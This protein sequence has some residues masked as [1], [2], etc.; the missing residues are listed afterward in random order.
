MSV[1]KTGK[2]L[3]INDH[4][5]GW[6]AHNRALAIKRHVQEYEVE[7]VAGMDA[8]HGA[9]ARATNLLRDEDWDIIH[10]NFS[11][12]A[13][14]FYN[15]WMKNYNTQ[16]LVIT[17]IGFRMKC[18]DCQEEGPS[19][20][21][22]REMI[23]VSRASVGL[24]PKIQRFYN[25]T[26]HI[27]NGVWLDR[28]KEP[29]PFVIGHIGPISTGQ[30]GHKGGW[31][32]AEVAKRLGAELKTLEYKTKQIPHEEMPAWW[33]SVDCLVMP[34]ISESCNNQV[35]ECLAMNVPVYVT[36][37]G[38]HEWLHPYVHL[39]ERDVDSIVDALKSRF[40][41]SIIEKDYE[42]GTICRKWKKLYD[43]V[44]NEPRVRESGRSSSGI[45]PVL[46]PG[47]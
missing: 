21:Q 10:L 6:S 38:C 13:N 40:T 30:D 7:I 34:S 39:I 27:P 42:M 16:R 32:V 37:N 24:N 19:R 1:R 43:E 11:S 23:A 47:S 44:M 28:F 41:R 36:E 45:Q 12:G 35:M 5:D 25:M 3:L 33:R 15:Y 8:S 22:F 2:V 20:N 29:K 14:H 17:A 9:T 31:Y 26:H 46:Q 18:G 4:E